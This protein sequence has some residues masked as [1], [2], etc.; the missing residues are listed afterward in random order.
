MIASQSML[1]HSQ[2]PLE[3]TFTPACISYIALLCIMQV[4]A[5]TR[6]SQPLSRPV[7][8]GIF[9]E[10]DEKCASEDQHHVVQESE[11]WTVIMSCSGQSYKAAF[12][13]K[14][15]ACEACL[16]IGSNC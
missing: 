3:L 9:R 11:H 14:E 10:T 6:Q 15:A 12:P 7:T 8:D 16:A 5:L 1:D 13:S 2:P 4:P